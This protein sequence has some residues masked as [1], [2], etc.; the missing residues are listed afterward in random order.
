MAYK[1]GAIVD[2]TSTIELYNVDATTGELVINVRHFAEIAA[3]ITTDSLRVQQLT[4][5]PIYT[6]APMQYLCFL[7]DFTT[8]TANSASTTYTIKHDVWHS[9]VAPSTSNF[10]TASSLFDASSY[11]LNSSA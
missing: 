8:V 5:M 6:T 7:T 11:G 3:A 4:C 2:A 9:T 1:Y 10:G